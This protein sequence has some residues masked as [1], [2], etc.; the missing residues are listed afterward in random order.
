MDWSLKNYRCPWR[1]LLLASLVF[2]VQANFQPERIYKLRQKVSLD[3]GWK[4]CLNSPSGSGNPYDAGYNDAAW[5]TVNVPHSAMYVAP[6]PAGEKTTMPGGAWTGICWYRKF[7]SIPAGTHTQKVFLEFEAAMQS[8]DVYLNGVRIG[9]HG[10]S[11]YTPFS[12]DISSSVNRTGANVLAVRCD[13]NYSH[14][15]PPGNVPLSG[16]GEYPD[17]YIYSGLCRD[18]WLVCADNVYIPLYGQKITAAVS[19]SGATVR[20]RTMVANATTAAASCSVQSVVVNASDAIVGQANAVGSVAAGGSLLFDCATPAISNSGLWT[21]ETPNLYRV[22]TKVYVNNAAVDDNV[23]RIGFRTLSWSTAGGFFL[24]GARYVLKG[25]CHHQ[26]FA[27]VGNALPNSRYYEEVRLI[28]NMGA[29]AIRCAHYPRDPAF[30]DA[31]DELGVICEPELPSWGGSITSYNPIFWNRMDSCADAMVTSAINHP[32]IIMWG[33]FNEAA[34]DFPTQFTEIHNRI[35]NLDSTRF[36]TFINNKSQS[37]DKVTDIFGQNYSFMPDWA[38]ARYY[39]SEYHEGWI[40]SC[41][42]GDTATVSNTFECYA[43]G[44]LSESENQYAT[45]RYNQRWIRDILNKTGQSLPL[46]GGHMWCFADYWTPCNVGNHPMGVVDHYRIP[47]KVFYTFR[48]NWTGTAPDTFVTGITPTHVQLDADLP[49]INADSTDITCVVASLRD[50]SGRLAYANRGVTL[51]LTGP[52]DCFD[53]LTRTTIAG[54]IGWVLKSRNIPGTITATVT[55]SGLTDGTI[56]IRSVA[57]DNSALPFIWQAESVTRGSTPLTDKTIKVFKKVGAIVI[58][59]PRFFEKQSLLS[60]STVQG[61]R[62][63]RQTVAGGSPAVLTTRSLGMGLYYLTISGNGAVV[64][65]KIM[66]TP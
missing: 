14:D 47:K 40:Y 21:P 46:A 7:F 51:A 37:A 18:V 26:E 4:F 5:Q 28:K 59:F 61:R 22:F 12:F 57:P 39:N 20:V 42:R 13:C 38:G 6:T 49:A 11:G 30:Y 53:T 15:I 25:V 33:L 17:F 34:G 1:I 56:T 2:P 64:T 63:V 27:W 44:C 36:T 24:N 35:K 60:L 48:Y 55:S 43:G 52:A 45:E 66:V 54:K 8:T 32:S 3:A 50:A 9:G 62:V 65:Q 29:N 23:E 58:L 16:M 19:S 41:K 31:C 10:A